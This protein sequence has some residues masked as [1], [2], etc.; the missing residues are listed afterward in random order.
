M[1]ITKNPGSVFN[2]KE[3]KIGPLTWSIKPLDKTKNHDS[4]GTTSSVYFHEIEVESIDWQDPKGEHIDTVM[5]ELFHAI[6][7]TYFNES[8]LTEKQVHILG[9][10]FENLILGNPK[11]MK[12]LFEYSNWQ[13]SA[14]RRK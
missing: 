13:R 4:Q 1:A 2:V 8:N 14:K 7:S 12:W 11:F 5:H 3:I 9:H 6:S 10:A